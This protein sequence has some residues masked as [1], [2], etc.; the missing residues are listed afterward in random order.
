MED[1]RQRIE[2][3]E[4]ILKAV[5]FTECDPA[6]KTFAMNVHY[7]DEVDAAGKRL[8]SQL[9]PKPEPTIKFLCPQCG[10]EVC[11]MPSA[12]GKR[13][14]L[15]CPNC[16]Y[17]W[18]PPEQPEPIN[19]GDKFDKANQQCV[20]ILANAGYDSN[21]VAW[22]ARL[23]REHN[24][25]IKDVPEGERITLCPGG[26]Y[27]DGGKGE[28][29][30]QFEDI[31]NGGEYCTEYIAGSMNEIRSVKLDFGGFT[32]SGKLP[33]GEAKRLYGKFGKCARVVLYIDEET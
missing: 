18:S 26:D 30:I 7:T 29:V 20:A 13:L 33:H 12:E 3:I 4:T 24:E 10:E 19:E 25:L 2:D 9:M 8:R 15:D 31:F 1:L 17:M 5:V 21:L 14:L 11:A 16:R 32:L 27:R 22:I 6:S 23:L 28:P